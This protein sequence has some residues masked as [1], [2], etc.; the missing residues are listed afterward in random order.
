MDVYDT[1]ARERE[2]ELDNMKELN[3]FNGRYSTILEP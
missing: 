2:S 3:E 1:V